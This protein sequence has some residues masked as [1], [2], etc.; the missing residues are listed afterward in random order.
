MM[1]RRRAVGG[2]LVAVLL[3]TGGTASA[4]EPVG[5]GTAATFAVLGGSTVT[6]TGPSVIT[7]DVGVSPGTSITGFPPGEVRDGTIHADDEVAKQAQTDLTTAYN[8]AAGRPAT[9]ISDDLGG[10]TLSPG[11]YRSDA[12]ME[13]TG[14]VTLDGQ[15]DPAAVFIFQAGSTLITASSSVVALVRGAHPC[16][17]FWQVGSSAT[18]ATDSTFAG[19]VMALA[20]VTVESGAVVQ[21]RVLARTGA[22]TLDTNTVTRPTCESTTTSSTSTPTTSTPTTSTP[23]TTGPDSSGDEDKG[24]GGAGGTGGGAGDKDGDEGGNGGSGGGEGKDNDGGQGNGEKG[25]GS[26]GSP[27]VAIT[28]T[29]RPG[30]M[31]IPP[32]E[33]RRCCSDGLPDGL[34]PTGTAVPAM[35]TLGTVFVVLGALLRRTN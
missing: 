23:T 11:V 27:D 16:N 28:P 12:G 29:T 18:L 25:N 5:L 22:V 21:G 17:V 3:A 35:L 33:E 8:D 20:S 34:P 31:L 4:A 13:V 6:N 24:D 14:T 1:I 7:G 19:T 10:Q 26:G 2:L 30:V 9:P 15:G 32:A